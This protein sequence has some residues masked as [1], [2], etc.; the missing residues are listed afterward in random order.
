MNTPTPDP[1]LLTLRVE[2]TCTT[3]ERIALIELGKYVAREGD[4]P[5]GHISDQRAID[6]AV[7]FL[8]GVG[9]REARRKFGLD[10]ADALHD[11]EIDASK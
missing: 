8:V 10:P 3:H 7:T 9:V 11:W 1:A 6:R 4:E 2:L 5:V